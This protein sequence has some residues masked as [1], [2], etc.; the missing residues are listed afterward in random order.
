MPHKEMPAQNH[1]TSPRTK[2]SLQTYQS[3][4]ERFTQ[5]RHK[6]RE[7]TLH[8]AREDPITA[9]QIVH[10]RY[11]FQYNG[12][13]VRLW[14]KA[15]LAVLTDNL[16]ETISQDVWNAATSGHQEPRITELTISFA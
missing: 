3:N 7:L 13:S 16:A 8:E 2:L 11:F 6:Y 10:V 12:T 1:Y 9:S 14:P 4:P 5:Q 15:D